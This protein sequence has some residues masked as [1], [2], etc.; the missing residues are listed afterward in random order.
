[1]LGGGA[2]VAPWG[3]PRW[4]AEA[5]WGGLAPL[6]RV[7]MSC[8]LTQLPLTPPSPP[9]APCLATRTTPLGPAPGGRGVLPAAPLPQLDTGCGGPGG[10]AWASGAGKKGEMPPCLPAPLPAHPWLQ[11]LTP[12]ASRRVQLAGRAAPAAGCQGAL[13][14]PQADPASQACQYHPG[15]QA[16]QYPLTL[17][18][19]VPPDFQHQPDFCPTQSPRAPIRPWIC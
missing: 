15:S 10:P 2:V 11:P 13:D 17:S 9:D 6:P 4:I 19:S 3:W 8:H 18:L 1:M 16:F 12:V 7:D 14:R 5:W